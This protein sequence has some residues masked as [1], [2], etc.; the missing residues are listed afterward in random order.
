MKKQR[1]IGTGEA[2]TKS[3]RWRRTQDAIWLYQPPSDVISA[4]DL[5]TFARKPLNAEIA[6]RIG[7]SFRFV[8]FRADQLVVQRQDGLF[9]VLDPA[10]QVVGSGAE[11]HRIKQRPVSSMRLGC[12]MGAADLPTSSR[13]A[14]PDDDLKLIRPRFVVFSTSADACHQGR[15]RDRLVMVIHDDVAFDTEARKASPILSMVKVGESTPLWSRTLREILPGESVRLL[16]VRLVET[17]LDVWGG[18]EHT[19][20]RRSMDAWDGTPGAQTQW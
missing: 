1:F 14:L 18:S 9:F 6:A 17:R 7:G 16:G 3:S 8:R 19:V 2:I 15:L 5:R 20:V 12:S 10:L 11:E 4:L 13:G